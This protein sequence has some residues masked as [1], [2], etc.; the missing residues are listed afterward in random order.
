MSLLR[1]HF[2]LTLYHFMLNYHGLADN[3]LNVSKMTISFY[4]R[5]ENTVEKGE[6]A[7]CQHF[8]FS[9]GGFQSLLLSGH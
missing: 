3:K 2:C 1:P 8:S 4:D 5:V 7:D 6:N 9:H